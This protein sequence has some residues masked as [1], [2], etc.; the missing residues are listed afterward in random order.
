MSQRPK[1]T[2]VYVDGFN[3]YYGCLKGTPYRWLDLDAL[4]RKLLPRNDIA[5]IRYF[6]ALVHGRPDN[7]GQEQRQLTYLRA[8]RAYIPHLTIH[9]GKF[10]SSQVSARVVD[11]PPAYIKVHK[12]EE[13]GSDVNIASYLLMDA[14][15]GA[16]ETAV[17]ISNDTDLCTPISMVRDRFTL[18][19]LVFRPHD[20]FSYPLA[21]VASSY[22]PIRS[23]V[24]RASQLPERLTD[25]HGTIHKPAGW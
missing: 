20:H 11:P 18:P 9:E 13:K 14:V 7:P 19:V 21:Q 8:L 12:T 24:L 5:R 1:R 15:D 10:L 25:K 17:V 3:L 2:T 6:T 23:G 16:Y 22:R 4:C